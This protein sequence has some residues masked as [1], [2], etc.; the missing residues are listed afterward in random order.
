MD[1]RSTTND[2][3]LANALK[4]KSTED[5]LLAKGVKETQERKHRRLIREGR[6]N[7]QTKDPFSICGNSIIIIAQRITNETWRYVSAPRFYPSGSK[8]IGTKWYQGRVTL[9]APEGWE[10]PLP[11]S[12]PQTIPVGSGKRVI[13]RTLPPGKTIE[14]YANLQIG[15]EQFTL[16]GEDGLIYVKNIVD[17]Y[18]TSENKG[19]LALVSTLSHSY[20]L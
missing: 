10:Y 4:F 15:P 7:G 5:E 14:D 19:L 18:T 16:N 1:I 20:F 8:V 9:G 13:G 17:T 12:T 6:M 11:T 2:R 3:I